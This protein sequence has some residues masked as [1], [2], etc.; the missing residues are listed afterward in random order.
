MILPHHGKWPAIH[1][2]AW[3]A[4]SADLIGEV[5]LGADSSVWFGVVIRGDVNTITIGDRTNIQ[6]NSTLHVTRKTAKLVIGDDVTVGHQALL[7]GC[8]VGNRVLIGMGA[9][10]LDN[11]VIPDDSYVGAGALVTKNKTFPPGHL[12]LGSPAQA[13]RPL[14]PKEL[15]F[16]KKSAHHYV[17]DASEYKAY[18]RGPVRLGADISD[19][20][21]LET[22]ELE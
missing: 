3:V 12:I 18:V 10:I 7:H 16:L 1:E 2:T 22:E 14:E 6:D 17:G 20:E 15:E 11:A 13:V 5:S 19:L 9:I 21:R 4:P 8:Q